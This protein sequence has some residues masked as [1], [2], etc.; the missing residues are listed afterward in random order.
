MADEVEIDSGAGS[1]CYEQLDPGN[2][3]VLYLSMNPE[4]AS[5]LRTS[6][7][8]GNFPVIGSENILAALK[9]AASSGPFRFAGKILATDGLLWKEPVSG[10]SISVES[11]NGKFE[12]KTDDQGRFEF[13]QLTPGRYSVSFSHEGYVQSKAEPSKAARALDLIAAEHGCEVRFFEMTPDGK[14]SGKVSL[15]NG[16]PAKGVEVQAFKDLGSGY[17]LPVPAVIG[18]TDAAG[19]YTLRPLPPGDYVVRVK[20]DGEKPPSQTDMQHSPRFHLEKQQERSRV[21][22]VVP[23]G[24]PR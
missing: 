20:S 19:A 9:S 14:L 15:A 1:S 18:T 5:H 10:A 24:G 13:S 21:D 16:E 3:Y 4:N 22:L 8:A 2:Q 23:M 12:R 17:V 7:C 11:A 6:K